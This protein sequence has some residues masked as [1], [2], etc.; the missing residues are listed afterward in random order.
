[1]PAFSGSGTSAQFVRL[2]LVAV[3]QAF[4]VAT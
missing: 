1:M 4:H 3:W 2:Q